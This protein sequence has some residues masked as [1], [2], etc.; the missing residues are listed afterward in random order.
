MIV[1]RETKEIRL[2]S[3]IPFRIHSGKTY[4]GER[5]Q[6]LMDSIERV[7]LMVPV[8]VRPVADDK[9]EI[10]S[11]HNRAKAMKTLG[12]DVILVDIR[13]G[14]SNDDA[15]KLFYE[16]N[17]NQ[18][19]FSDWSY[20][21]RIEA[22]KYYETIIK[23]NSRQGRRTD[24]EEKKAEE[25]GNETSVQIGQK[26]EGNSKRETTRDKMAKSLGI[27]PATLS[28][29]RRIIKLPDNLLESI[30]ELLDKRRIT[31]EAAYIISRMEKIY[32]KILL[33]GINKYPD[34]EVD[35]KIIRELAHRKENN[36]DELSP[37]S[38]EMILE[39]LVTK[40]P[41]PDPVPI[42]GRRG[43]DM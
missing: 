18:Q 5:L 37:I 14:L 31:F 19:S 39:A 35:L 22:M 36:S 13:Y 32:I 30:A 43:Q 1:E 8:I 24:L 7:G 4:E 2:E 11:G 15:V 29:Y 38:R 20:S 12:R 25:I 27:S 33:D 41:L 40:N 3:L 21:Q 28:K 34:R 26:L 42:R 16:S 23:R 17:L 6:Q 9:Y 10:I